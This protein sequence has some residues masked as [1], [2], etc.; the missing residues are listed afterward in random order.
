MGHQDAADLVGL[1]WDDSPP[2]GQPSFVLTTESGAQE[3]EQ[4]SHDPLRPRHGTTTPSPAPLSI[5]QG[6]WG[7]RAGKDSTS[8]QKG[9]QDIVAKGTDRVCMCGKELGPLLQAIYYTHTEQ[10]SP[11]SGRTRPEAQGTQRWTTCT[12][13]STSL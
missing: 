4:M 1:R 9:L 10:S 5:G 2:A 6:R 3:R 12:I 7:R 11:Q 8:R 13:P